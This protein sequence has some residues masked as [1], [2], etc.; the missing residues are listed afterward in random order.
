[1]HDHGL[2]HC[3]LKLE[4]VMISHDVDSAD[5]GSSRSDDG[6]PRSDGGSSRSDGSTPH[7]LL[8]LIDLGRTTACG[9]TQAMGTP[10]YM[11]PSDLVKP[12]FLPVSPS[13]DFYALGCTLYKV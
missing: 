3:D 10:A 4:N 6:S 8:S 11:T 5:D 1:M 9:G 7:L 2:V 12:G 13:R